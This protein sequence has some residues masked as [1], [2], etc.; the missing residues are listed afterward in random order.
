MTALYLIGTA[1]ARFVDAT[2][3]TCDLVGAINFKTSGNLVG[4]SIS[5]YF[6]LDF[7]DKE[8]VMIRNPLSFVLGS[9]LLLVGMFLLAL[10][11][12]LVGTRAPF[13]IGMLVGMSLASGAAILLIGTMMDRQQ[14][15]E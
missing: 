1:A 14:E 10:H 7:L 2:V 13:G 9:C 15:K 8:D 6:L 11:G 12:T 3:S 4:V 5:G